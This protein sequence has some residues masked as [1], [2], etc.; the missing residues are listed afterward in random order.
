MPSQFEEYQNQV[1]QTYLKKKQKGTLPLNL[2]DPKPA[3]LRDECL[4]VLGKRYLS[5]DNKILNDFFGPLKEGKDYAYSIYQVDLNCFKPLQNFLKGKTKQP[6]TK[7]INLLAWLIDFEDRP[8]KFDYK[9]PESIIGGVS[10]DDLSEEGRDK[11]GVDFDCKDL[12]ALAEPENLIGILSSEK[13]EEQLHKNRFQINYFLV[14]V[15]ILFIGISVAVLGGWLNVFNKN[16]CMYWK[17]DHYE[18]IACNDVS[19][20]LSA[21]AI[22]E[23]RLEEFKKLRRLDTL[24]EDCIGKIWY[25]K[26]DNKLEF[27]T[28]SGKHPIHF[29]KGLKIVT[30]YIYKKYIL[31]RDSLSEAK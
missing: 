3:N 16:E 10:V 20:N 18:T 31:N 22:D 24:R 19:P 21:I 30:P 17:E 8:F 15:A 9:L 12:K 7:N 27:F 4:V 26:I 2:E 5:G 23:N 25:S 13:A 1:Y 28:N 11:I 14:L 29:N 6:E